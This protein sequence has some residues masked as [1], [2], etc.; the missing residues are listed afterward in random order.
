MCPANSRCAP[1]RGRA[2]RVLALGRLQRHDTGVD[3][4][5]AT[6]RQHF[7]SCAD[8]S[9]NALNPRASKKNQRI[10]SLVV[11]DREESRL[12]MEH[13]RGVNIASALSWLDLFSF[14]VLNR[15]VRA[16]LEDAFRRYEE[17]LARQSGVLLGMVETAERDGID[18]VLK[19]IFATKLLDSLRNPFCVQKALFTIGVAAD[20]EPRAPELR[21][22]YSRIRAGAK[23]HEAAICARFGLEPQEYEAWLQGL[24]MVVAVEMPGEGPILDA[25]LARLFGA[26]AWGAGVYSYIGGP[27]EHVCLLPDRG[28]N[29]VQNDRSSLIMEFNVSSRVFV[30]FGFVSVSETLPET[31]RRHGVAALV[32]GL[33]PQIRVIHKDLPELILYNQRTVYQ[34]REGVYSA[35]AS[36]YGVHVS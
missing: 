10:Y 14:D 31:V 33:D 4:L 32:S 8:L 36:P 20:Y 24:F 15:C 7:V 12:R 26:S 5:N 1:S 23:P 11:E 27:S 19:S 17:V 29:T 28:F 16:N 18:T 13:P 30:R 6:R 21:A 2:G 9:R 22:M 35:S 3:F 34:C 25:A